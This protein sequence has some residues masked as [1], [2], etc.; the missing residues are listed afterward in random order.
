[1]SLETDR[2]LV[3]G[4]GVGAR[5][6]QIE[7]QQRFGETE[8]ER[9]RRTD[10]QTEA[11]TEAETKADRQID[12]VKQNAHFLAITR[13][14]SVEGKIHPPVYIQAMFY[15]TPYHT[16]CSPELEDP[17]GLNISNWTSFK[18]NE[19]SSFSLI[20]KWNQIF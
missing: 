5:H 11:E 6:T 15:A 14:V 1:M 17:R 12:T 8:T 3:R 9:D 2:K 18:G 16:N 10:T 7:A 20:P 4:E 13:F 19:S